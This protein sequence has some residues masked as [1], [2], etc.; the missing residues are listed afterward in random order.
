MTASNEAFC[1]VTKAIVVKALAAS[2]DCHLFR[3]QL[4]SKWLGVI[5]SANQPLCVCNQGY[6]WDGEQCIAD[7]CSGVDCGENASCI[8]TNDNEALCL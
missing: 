1:A 4:W 5:T 2:N 6:H 3:S 8:V 7:P